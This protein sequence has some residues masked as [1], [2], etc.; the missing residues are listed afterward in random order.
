MDFQLDVLKIKKESLKIKI[1]KKLTKYIVVILILVV[2]KTSS[3]QFNLSNGGFFQWQG[4]YKYTSPDEEKYNL[5]IW[6][7][8]GE[9]EATLSYN[10]GMFS[11]KIDCMVEFLGNDFDVIAIK[12]MKINDGVCLESADLEESLTKMGSFPDMFIFSMKN[13]I[14]Q[15]EL[16]GYGFVLHG[17]KVA[18][19]KVAFKK[20]D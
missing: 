7:S 17:V 19:P 18:K 1:M 9:L 15:T 6:G 10:D 4:E 2:A 3:A 20:I 8:E 11:Y 13:D 14:I 16:M 12:F 5:F